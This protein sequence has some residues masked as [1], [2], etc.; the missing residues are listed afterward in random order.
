MF[1]SWTKSNAVTRR[2][3]AAGAAAIAGVGFA[4]ASGFAL[5]TDTLT[6]GQFRD[7][8]VE[9]LRRERPNWKLE[10]PDNPL[11]LLV[12]GRPTYLAN[13]YQGAIAATG[14]RREKGILSFF[15][16]MASG[17]DETPPAN[18]DAVRT[19]LRARIVSAH[20]AANGA[21]DKMMLLSRPFS[22]KARIA[23]VID[24]PQ[25]MSFVSKRDPDKW[26]VTA[27]AIHAAAVE[28]LDAIS[29]DVPIEPHA[30]PTGSGLFVAMGGPDG[31]VAA[32]LLAPKFMARMGEE[33][34]AE[35]FVGVP[36]RDA[37]LAWSVDCSTK[38]TFATLLTKYASTF[39]YPLTDEIFVWSADGVRLA[40]PIE[41]VEHG[42]G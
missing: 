9:L 14:P 5:A 8:V 1:R 27:D 41:L 34:G 13:L 33:L 23:Y 29:G 30:P 3:A 42:R 19:R 35:H 37:L 12:N 18:F 24:S 6:S 28:N 21:D 10:L 38:A 20:A 36:S 4:L 2:A 25:T 39:P 31:Y 17:F 32:R 11:V 15:D 16:A 7:E 26:M 40:N 22:R